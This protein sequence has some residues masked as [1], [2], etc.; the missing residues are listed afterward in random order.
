M[1][2]ANSAAAHQDPAAAESD[3]GS[4]AEQ[5]AMPEVFAFQHKLFRSSEDCLFRRSADGSKEPV[6]VLNIAESEYALPFEGIQHEFG[7]DP[8]SEDGRMLALVE[9]ALHYTRTIR[10]GDPVPK[11][12]ITGE[13][14]WDI[15]DEH[16]RIAQQRINVQLAG[17]LAGEDNLITDP[18]QLQQV[19]DDPSTR[20]KVNEA[21]DRAAEELGLGENGKEELLDRIEALAEDL[22]GIEALRDYLDR[23]R[24]IRRKV[25]SLSAAFSDEMSLVDL[26]LPVSRLT[27]QALNEFEDEFELLDAQTGEIIGVLRNLEAQTKF[28]RD[29]RDSLRDRLVDWDEMFEKF[30]PARISSSDESA[31]LLREAYRFLAPRFMQVDQW[32]LNTKVQPK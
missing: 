30:G 20:K 19:A 32:D 15:T 2:S 23:I 13:A 21:L 14:S 9:E 26:A 31:N 28:I 7:I 6:F 16:R 18:D 5:E 29:S 24:M 3:S 25:D 22:A 11:E 27:R 4:S 10:P 8:E 1:A 17:W 12:M